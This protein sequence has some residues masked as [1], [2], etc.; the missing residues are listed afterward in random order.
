[1]RALVVDDEKIS[2]MVLA[3]MLGPY[4]EVDFA[5]SGEEAISKV[6][7]AFDAGRPYSLV[8]LDYQLPGLS[9]TRT[10]EAIRVLERSQ[11]A[12]Y[13]KSV[14]CVVSGSTEC[15]A[16]FFSVLGNNEDLFF[17]PKPFNKSDIFCAIAHAYN[18]WGMAGRDNAEFLPSCR[19]L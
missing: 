19:C 13:P 12:R 6:Q 11:Q 9:G 2:S 18:S 15:Y 7:A 8:C 1:M 3:A 5:G 14:F 16:E 4:C 17:A 10:G